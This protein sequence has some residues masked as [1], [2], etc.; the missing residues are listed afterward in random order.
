MDK[1]MIRAMSSLLNYTT[2]NI[3]K[4]KLEKTVA[5]ETICLSLFVRARLTN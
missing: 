5:K 3:Y 2:A 1:G 4:N